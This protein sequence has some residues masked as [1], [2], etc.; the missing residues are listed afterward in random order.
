MMWGT[1][2]GIGWGLAEATVIDAILYVV[3]KEAVL[4]YH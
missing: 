4:K 1:C 2:H 3:G